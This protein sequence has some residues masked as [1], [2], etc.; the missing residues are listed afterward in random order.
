M[1]DYST[2][3]EKAG[4]RVTQEA[5]SMLYTRYR[6]A[7]EFIQG[8]RL[9]EVACGEGIGLRYLAQQAGHAIGGDVTAKLIRRARHLSPCTVSLL[10]LE[11]EALP[12]GTATRDV[13]VCYEAMYYI[14]RVPAFLQECRRVLTSQGV[15][16]LCTAN[17]EWLDFNPSPHSRRYYSARQLS[18]L[19]Q[20]AGFQSESF[21][22]FST[23]NAS[24][25]A[26]CLSWLK[27]IAVK[28]HLIPSTMEGKQLLK[29]LFLGC[30]VPFPNVVE[31]GM[32]AYVPPQS[33]PC[34]RPVGDYKVLFVV[35]RPA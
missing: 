2:V 17:P 23:A 29:R 7:K 30:L 8:K 14:E 35:A 22:A 31:D 5:L 24:A 34:D 12:L 28:W 1:L 6:F 20:E 18:V 19:L 27:R 10:R 25:G 11:A 4:D 15:L 3:T 26:L 9:L 32:A 13:V 16:L 33:I 21:G